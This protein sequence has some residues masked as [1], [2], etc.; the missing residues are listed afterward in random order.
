MNSNGQPIKSNNKRKFKMKKCKHTVADNF[1]FWT[2][3]MI[4]KSRRYLDT[5]SYLS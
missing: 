2:I 5:I 1:Y 3:L 4:N